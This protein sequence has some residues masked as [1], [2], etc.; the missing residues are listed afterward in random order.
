MSDELNCLPHLT[1]RYG[2]KWEYVYVLD[3]KLTPSTECCI[4][5][6]GWFPGVWNLYADVSGHCSETSAYKFQPQGNHPKESILHLCCL[7]LHAPP[8]YIIS[9]KS[10][11][12]NSC[13]FGEGCAGSRRLAS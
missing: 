6:F 8:L 13:E 11:K 7:P 9:T 3:F 12:R 10:Y 1:L 5:S 4:L 2:N